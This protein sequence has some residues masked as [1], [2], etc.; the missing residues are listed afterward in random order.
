[1]ELKELIENN[2]DRINK[3]WSLLHLNAELSYEEYRTQEI[4]EEFLLDLGIE[5]QRIFN[6]GITAVMNS[7]DECIA[8]RADMDAL[9]IKGAFH[10]C[11][12]DYHMTIA[13][14]T[15]LILSKLGYDKCVKFIFQPGEE[16][17]GGAKP[18]IEEG[19]LNNP[20][21]KSIIGFHVWPNV[22]VGT[23]EVSSGASMAS[24]DDFNITFKGIGGHAATPHLCKNPLYPAIDFIQTMNLKSKIEF[25]PLDSHLITFSSM[26]CGNVP[27]VIAEECT[28][29]GTV[30]T[31]DNA[32]RNEMHKS[33]LDTSLVSAEK[34]G[35]CAE[36]K[37]DFQYPPLIGEERLTEHFID[38]AKT[39]I[40]AENVLPLK[41]TFAA[42]DFA[43]FAE[44]IPAVHFR[45]GIADDTSGNYPLHSP[46]FNASKKSIFYGIYIITNF[47][48]SL[49]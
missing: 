16:A 36:I 12:H 33:I 49:G 18:M 14:G 10:G 22:K 20:E 46:Y 43:F 7:G 15:A 13:L 25:D 39:I 31:F 44:S 4:I 9:P 30:R 11:G 37:Y 26:Q 27:N 40:G 21:V 28:I 2:L 24:V 41:K 6:T 45:L 5:T 17:E 34:Y 35:C 8:I 42:E 1:M 23:I 29:L 47:L 19:V 38:A 48:L 3:L 32:L